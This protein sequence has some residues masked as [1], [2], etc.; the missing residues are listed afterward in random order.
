MIISCN[1]CGKKFVVPDKAISESG[2]LV[3]CSACG[4]KWTQFPIGKKTIT[5]EKVSE[6]KPIKKKTINPPKKIKSTKNKRAKIKK[7]T[8]PDLYS[9]EYLAKKHGIKI[10]GEQVVKSNNA[11]VKEKVNLGFYSILIISI[12]TIITFLRILYFGQDFLKEI[13]PV[14][15]IYLDYLFE[16]IRNIKEIIENFILGY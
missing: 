5:T 3:Q 13:F 9:P 15:E 7:K 2:R 12:I 1:S 10:G 11:K 14:S 4:N 8:G 16:S 6:I